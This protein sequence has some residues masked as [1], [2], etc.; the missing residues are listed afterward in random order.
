MR[1]STKKQPQVQTNQRTVPS[2]NPTQDN[3][4]IS[5]FWTGSRWF[6]CQCPRTHLL[7]LTTESRK[8]CLKNYFRVRAFKHRSVSIDQVFCTHNKQWWIAK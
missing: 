4:N 8:C 1:K 7:F 2:R 6:C 3:G 5:N